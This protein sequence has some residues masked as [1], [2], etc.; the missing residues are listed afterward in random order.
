MRAHVELKVSAKG[1][2]FTIVSQ[3]ELPFV[4]GSFTRIVDQI[5]LVVRCD[6]DGVEED[7]SILTQNQLRLAIFSEDWE[8]K[9]EGKCEVDGAAEEGCGQQENSDCCLTT[10]HRLESIELSFV[11][12]NKEK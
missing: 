12:S 8:V 9:I 2:S 10:A 4:D 1:C 5:S 3:L 6:L 11:R 7:V